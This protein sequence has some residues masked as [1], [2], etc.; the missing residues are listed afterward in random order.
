MRLWRAGSRR[1]PA[2]ILSTR[3][4]VPSVFVVRK[5]RQFDRYL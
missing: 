2:F 1:P 5:V 3:Y 4:A